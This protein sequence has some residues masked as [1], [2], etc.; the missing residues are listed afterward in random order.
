VISTNDIRALEL[1]ELAFKVV[2][3]RG[4]CLTLGVTP[5]QEYRTETLTI[6]YLPKS[7]HMEVWS[8]RKVLTIERY[9]GNLRV[10]RYSPGE[11]EDELEA[12]ASSGATT[13][14]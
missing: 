12:V 4:I 11:W 13:N 1:Y 10:I 6:H 7:G 2:E 3:G 14:G 9:R 8:G 5:F